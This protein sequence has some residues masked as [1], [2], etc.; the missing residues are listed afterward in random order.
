MLQVH[1]PSS[2]APKTHHQPTPP[3]AMTNPFPCTSANVYINKIYSVKA[4]SHLMNWLSK[5]D[6]TL[7]LKFCIITSSWLAGVIVCSP[8]WHNI[9]TTMNHWIMPLNKNYSEIMN[10]TQQ[11]TKYKLRMLTVALICLHAITVTGTVYTSTW[12][13]NKTFIWGVIF[14]CHSLR[15]PRLTIIMKNNNEKGG[16]SVIEK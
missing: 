13:V 11:K 15:H 2:N 1:E 9:Q 12:K 14:Q 7:H 6:P 16:W 5:Q 8:I 3:Q 4:K 10:N